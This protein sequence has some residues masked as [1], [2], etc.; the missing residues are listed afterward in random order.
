M[1]DKTELGIVE[2]KVTINIY[3]RDLTEEEMK[4]T[5]PVETIVLL[6][7]KIVERISYDEE[8]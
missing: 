5:T 3:D 6:N 4:V 1:I 8:E 2:E 7:G